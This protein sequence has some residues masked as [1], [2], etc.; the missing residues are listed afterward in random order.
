LVAGGAAIENY[1]DIKAVIEVMNDNGM[2]FVFYNPGID[3]VLLLETPA[4]CQALRPACH[5]YPQK[6]IL[7]K[8]R[9]YPGE[10][11]C[12]PGVSPSSHGLQVGILFVN[13]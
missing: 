4:A 12:V 3:S 7:S 1:A 11:Y 13:S 10:G 9:I 5:T 6:N 2:D 8:P